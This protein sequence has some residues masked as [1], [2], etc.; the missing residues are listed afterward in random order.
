MVDGML[1]SA[2][3][4]CT[5]NMLATRTCDACCACIVYTLPSQADNT[6]NALQVAAAVATEAYDTGNSN[7]K[8]KPTDML[9]YIKSK[10]WVPGKSEIDNH[11]HD[12]ITAHKIEQDVQEARQP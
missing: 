8:Q 12:D 7:L 3:F 6:Y 1:L 5:F 10:M 9:K 11:E 4:L 2:C